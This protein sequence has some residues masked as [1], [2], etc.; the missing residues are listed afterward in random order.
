MDTTDL[1]S[2]VNLYDWALKN[3]RIRGERF[4]IVPPLKPIYEDSAT[5][6][7]IEKAAQ[8]FISEFLINLAFFISSTHWA[9]R[10]NSLYIFPFTPQISDF[11]NARVEPEILGSPYLSR[12][13]ELVKIDLGGAATN[14]IGMKQF[15]GGFMYFRGST[16]RQQIISVDA[17]GVIFDEVDEMTEGTIEAGKKRASSSTMPI[18]RG[19]STP[20][21]PHT[22]IDTLMERSDRKEWIV[23]CD[24][25]NYE[26]DLSRV[27]D[28]MFEIPRDNDSLLRVTENIDKGTHFHMGTKYYVGCPKCKHIL[29]VW[30]GQWI[31]TLTENPE[32]GGYHVPKLISNRLPFDEL[33]DKVERMRVG[34]LDETQIQEFHNSDLGLPRA[35]EGT[36]L[37]LANIIAC[38]TDVPEDFVFSMRETA[39]AWESWYEFPEPIRASFIGVDIGFK[40]LHV[41]ILADPRHNQCLQ[42]ISPNN[43]P[44]LVYAGSVFTKEN[45]H[46][47]RELDPYHAKWASLRTVVDNMPDKRNA[48]EFQRRHNG[49]AYT[50]T[51][52]KWKNKGNF[53]YD[54]D[55]D[56]GTV[57]AGR[58]ETLDQ[59]YNIILTRRLILPRNVQFIGGNVNNHHFGEFTAHLM[60]VTKIF[61]KETGAYDYVEGN[62]PDHFLHSLN[63]AAIAAELSPLDNSELRIVPNSIDAVVESFAAQQQLFNV[64]ANMQLG[65][66]KMGGGRN[67]RRFSSNRGGLRS[68][69][70][71]N[72]Y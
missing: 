38:S 14:N 24:H 28:V 46:G 15:R 55:L 66:A 35:P 3:R 60:N 51:Y 25:C 61:N 4:T 44:V 67:N 65:S 5:E 58:T 70:G 2:E 50:C 12:Q 23:K 64:F 39:E 72:G 59:V 53:I 11:S 54:Y 32:F 10:G 68:G 19:A 1:L 43:Y 7:Y 47:F 37:T 34:K 45:I 49:R 69:P 17:D 52:S 29:N 36:Q 48:A 71:S 33:A 63:Y 27:D 13:R 57:A 62:K 41:T 20:K 9:N 26:Q 8:V 56:K 22:G 21:F 42:R 30:N 40:R 16:Q 6:V 18:Y 31:P